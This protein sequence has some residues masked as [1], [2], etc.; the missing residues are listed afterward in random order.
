MPIYITSN[1]LKRAQVQD[2]YYPDCHY[3]QHPVNIVP[4]V[5]CLW[6]QINWGC[7]VGKHLL[8]MLLSETAPRPLFTLFCQTYLL[9]HPHCHLPPIF[10]KDN[11]LSLRSVFSVIPDLWHSVSK[12]ISIAPMP[13]SCQKN[14]VF[15]HFC[16][17]IQFFRNDKNL[18]YWYPICC[19][20]SQSVLSIVNWF[21][22]WRIRS[23]NRKYN[24]PVLASIEILRLRGLPI[25]GYH[26][27]SH[28]GISKDIK[29]LE[30]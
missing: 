6:G 10:T 18:F 2:Q 19:D 26:T 11:H 29:F 20:D 21:H 28:P 16:N 25:P 7:T 27:L 5:S 15:T 14:A 22:R 13:C 23:I 1:P 12:Y 17:K 30:F 3:H 4:P 24:S 8:A 9:S